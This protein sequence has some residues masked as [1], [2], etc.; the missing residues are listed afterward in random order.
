VAT[1]VEQGVEQL[2]AQARGV[3]PPQRTFYVGDR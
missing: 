3:D 1:E 2:G